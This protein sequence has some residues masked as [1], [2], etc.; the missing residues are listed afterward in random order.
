M[1]ACCAKTRRRP[2]R[3]G[4]APVAPSQGSVEGT[5]FLSIAILGAAL[6]AVAL[7]GATPIAT[8]I[9]VA[10]LSPLVV[11]MLR[12]ALAALLT[13]PLLVVWRLRPPRR[14]DQLALL[15][16][17]TLGGLIAFPLLFS[18]GIG[19]T[20]AAHAGL[21]L[22]ALPLPTGLIGAVFERVL[23]PLSWWLGAAV[24]LFGEALLIGTDA[25]AAAPAAT[26][27]G[28]LLVAAGAV[29]AAAGHVAGARLAPSFGTW[30]TT[31]WAI[32][33]GGALLLPVLLWRSDAAALAAAGTAAWSAVVFLAGG[34][35]LLA[36]AAWYWALSRGGIARMGALQF[37]QPLVTLTLAALLLAEPITPSLLGAAALILAGVGLTQRR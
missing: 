34:S 1:R 6:A 4:S 31:L 18:F 15:S 26:L 33:A 32:T 29:C 7:W 35:T 8:K 36:F 2:D 20:S 10:D 22:A 30:P 23:P 37:L 25:P 12:T 14:R 24:A 21:I 5:G 13:V 19:R 11:G 9:A 3:A 28:D 16:L 17:V 27:T